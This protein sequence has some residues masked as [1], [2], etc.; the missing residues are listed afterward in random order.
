MDSRLVSRLTVL[1]DAL[2]AP[3]TWATG[4]PGQGDVGENIVPAEL[5]R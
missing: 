3:L 2:C 4:V 1:A 5:R